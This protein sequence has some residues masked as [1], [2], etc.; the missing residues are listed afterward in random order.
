MKATLTDELKAEIAEIV[1]A[2]WE[3]K[4]TSISE[5]DHDRYILMLQGLGDTHRADTIQEYMD[6]EEEDFDEPANWK[7]LND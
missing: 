5:D 3:D 2:D 7:D 1:F 4:K 6:L